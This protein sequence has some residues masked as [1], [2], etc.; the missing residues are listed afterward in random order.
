VDERT[1]SFYYLLIQHIKKLHNEVSLDGVVMSEASRAITLGK[2]PAESCDYVSFAPLRHY[3]KSP[4][5]FSFLT[6]LFS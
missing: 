5:R 6:A 3:R 2:Y 4:S 1:L